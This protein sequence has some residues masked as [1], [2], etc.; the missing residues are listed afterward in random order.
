MVLVEAVE[1]LRGS[2]VDRCNVGSPRRDE[3]SRVTDK[4]KKL[5]E[6]SASGL[7]SL[8]D[9]KGSEDV[10]MPGRLVKKRTAAG[11]SRAF[12]DMKIGAWASGI[13]SC[14]GMV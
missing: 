4:F 11:S 6:S 9:F 14:T 10:A 7:L 12:R 8:T 2:C 13:H 5:Q 3:H 1:V